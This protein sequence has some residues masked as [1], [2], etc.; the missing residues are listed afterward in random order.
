MSRLEKLGPSPEHAK[1]QALMPEFWK[2]VQQQEQNDI[3]RG[4][5]AQGRTEFASTWFDAWA[6]QDIKKID[7]CIAEDC[8]YIDS[9]TFQENRLGRQVTIDNCQAAFDVFPDFAFYPQDGSNRSLP[10]WDYFDNQWRVTIPWRGIGRMIGQTI[11]PTTGARLKGTGRCLNF[12]GIDRYTLTEDFKI[13]H[14]DTDWDMLYGAAQLAGLGHLV[15]SRSLQKIGLRAASLVAPAFR[16][17]TLL[18]AR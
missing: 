4:L 13:T 5:P 7:Y 6:E 11:E 8:S 17:A 10:Y 18:T 16:L 3:E 9:T 14:I 2:K 15:R 1:Y 12:I